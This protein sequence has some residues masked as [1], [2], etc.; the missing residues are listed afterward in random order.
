M[1]KYIIAAICLILLS[2]CT[3]VVAAGVISSVTETDIGVT[4]TLTSPISGEILVI[5]AQ[6]D[7]GMLAKATLERINALEGETYE[8]ELIGIAADA[9]VFAWSGNLQPLQAH[10]EEPG[11]EPGE[12][13]VGDGIIHLMKTEIDA[14]GIEGVVAEG[15]VV[16]ITEPG[17]YI[18]EGTLYDGQIV[19]SDNL[20]KKKMR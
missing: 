4:V 3:N 12:E 19:V 13:P 16:T 15:T 14:T 11:D 9:S 10:I 17:D 2:L 5:G 6:Y 7:E 20:G 18:I 8:V 1:R